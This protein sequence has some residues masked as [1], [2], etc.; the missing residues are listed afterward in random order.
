MTAGG[1]ELVLE[2]AEPGKLA[3][4]G[5][6]T[7]GYCRHRNSPEQMRWTDRVLCL[8][9]VCLYSGVPGMGRFCSRGLCVCVGEGFLMTSPVDLHGK[10]VTCR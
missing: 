8:D 9:S 2:A 5:R 1:A 10:T 7:R 3:E 4:P 6:A